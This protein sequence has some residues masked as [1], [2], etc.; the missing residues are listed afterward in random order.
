MRHHGILQVLWAYRIPVN[1]CQALS[2]DVL[3]IYDF[4]RRSL[5]V[6]Q[7]VMPCE[8]LPI[9]FFYGGIIIPCTGQVGLG[10]LLTCGIKV[11]VLWIYC[12]VILLW[13]DNG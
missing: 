10:Y 5:S 6:I 7:A 8:E 2:D 4:H 1:F 11:Y 3:L 12:N 9:V 13:L